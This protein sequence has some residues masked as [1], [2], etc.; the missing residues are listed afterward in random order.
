[1]PA[2]KPT[3]FKFGYHYDMKKDKARKKYPLEYSGE[4][5]ILLFGVNGAGKST[6][7]LIENLVTLKN[8]SLVVIDVKGELTAQT[9]RMRKTLGDVKIIDPY[10][11]LRKDC[12]LDLDSDGFN[13][14]A[15][16]DPDDDEF[17]DD[18][19]QLTMAIIEVEG[20]T[21]K[22]F[23]ES[24][25]GWFCVGLMMEVIAAKRETRAPSMLEARRWCLQPDLYELHP[26]GETESLIAGVRLN[27]QKAMA[28]GGQLADLAGGFADENANQK[29]TKSILSTLRT[30]TEFLISNPIARDVAK[31]NWSFA[32]LKERPT[33]VFIVLPPKQLHDKRRWTRLLITSALHAHLHPGPYKTLFILDEFRT[34]IGHLQIVNDF[35]S[36]VR[37]YG[38][39]F[40]PVCQSIT[41]LQH[42]FKE[43]WP[44]YAGQA[45][46]V[47]TIG[48]PGED[49][50]AAWMSKQGGNKTIVVEGWNEGESANPQGTG[51][52]SGENRSQMARP[53]MLPQEIRSMLPGTGIIW[54]SGEGERLFP[55]F[56][57]EYR[58]RP[59]IFPAL[60][61]PNPYHDAAAW[62]GSAAPTSSPS[63]AAP[64]EYSRAAKLFLWLVMHLPK[65]L[66]RALSENNPEEFLASVKRFMV[67]LSP[68]PKP[69]KPPA[70]PRSLRRKILNGVASFGFGCVVFWLSVSVLG[71]SPVRSVGPW[72]AE[73]VPS[74]LAYVPAASGSPSSAAFDAGKTDWNNW[75]TWVHGK[76]GELRAGIDFWAEVRNDKERRPSSCRLAM[77]GDISAEF[78][79]GCAAANKFLSVV[80]RRRMTEPDYRQGWNAGYKT[81][82]N[83]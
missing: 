25:Q 52:S 26:D 41:Q 47:A 30:Q 69:P 2:P 73:H 76:S 20:E 58:D 63:P 39:Q 43:E 8:R 46:A 81:T 68:P 53:V 56:A 22:F 59:E 33:T 19:K 80:D 7:I 24:A 36:L 51:S 28:E 66:R 42:L 38:V 29:E 74:L 40:M 44:N 49:V 34:T 13:P 18:A 71:Y 14:L 1:M 27:A 82:G 60:I 37:G 64:F 9:Y 4:R 45:G 54:L 61:D 79:D 83:P 72:V 50:T 70:P 21:Q 35:W 65:W 5:H 23:P 3:P 55:Y 78:F 11:V 16:L 10:G 77:Q 12:R 32:Q 17:F 62:W 48:A 67:V 6:R 75:F 15:L 31:G 57:P